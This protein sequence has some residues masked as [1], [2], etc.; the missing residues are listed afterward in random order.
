MVGRIP[1]D[2]NEN[3]LQNVPGVT[4]DSIFGIV[5]NGTLSTN[6]RVS[7]DLVS[8]PMDMG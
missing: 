1:F 6:G 4:N 5:K 8:K 3:N 2:N 7:D